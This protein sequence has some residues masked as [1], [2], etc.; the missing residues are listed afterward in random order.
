MATQST[1][2]LKPASSGLQLNLQALN[3]KA[4]NTSQKNNLLSTP[5][6][7]NKSGEAEDQPRFSLGGAEDDNK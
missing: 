3:E 7:S 4:D 2:N 5:S 1:T 6:S